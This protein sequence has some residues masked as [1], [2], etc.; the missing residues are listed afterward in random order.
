[1]PSGTPEPVFPQP[2]CKDPDQRSPHNAMSK[3]MMPLPVGIDTG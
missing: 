3:H 2:R 1:M